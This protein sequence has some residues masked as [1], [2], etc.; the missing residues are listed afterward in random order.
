[1]NTD[2]TSIDLQNNIANQT[3]EKAVTATEEKPTADKAS[4]ELIKD[5]DKTI[6][7][8]SEELSTEPVVKNKKHPKKTK[9]DKPANPNNI[10]LENTPQWVKD[11]ESGTKK[12]GKKYTCIVTLPPAKER[13]GVIIFKKPLV[14]V[15]Q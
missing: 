1:M 10:A 15:D 6:T 4:Q 12:L 11:A 3:F 14:C 7:T 2:V 9:P 5:T 13:H 8:E